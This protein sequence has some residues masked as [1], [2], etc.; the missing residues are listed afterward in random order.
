MTQPPTI[1]LAGPVMDTDDGGAEWRRDVVTQY[2]EQYEFRNP[3]SKYNVPA[4]DVVV[5][6]GAAPRPDEV[7]VSELVTTDKRLIDE[8]DGL[9]V[10]YS[11]RRSVGTPMEVMWAYERDYPVALWIRDNTAISDLSPWYRH[12]ASAITNSIELALGHIDREVSGDE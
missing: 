11:K 5:V 7:S 6:D 3:L 8:S 12:H 9:L 4:S 2:G 10:G 1:Y